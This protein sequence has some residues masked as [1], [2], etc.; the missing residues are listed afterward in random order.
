MDYNLFTKQMTGDWIAQSTNYYLTNHINQ[1]FYT[2]N[3]QIKWTDIKEKEV[4]LDLIRT[5][6]KKEDIVK[7]ISLYKI[8]SIDVNSLSNLSYILLSQKTSKQICLFKF[9]K[10]FH[11][12][13][14]FTLKDY[15]KNY[16]C[17]SSDIRNIRVIEKIYFLNNNVKIIKS[18]IK[19][20]NQC[21]GASFSS[22]IK[23][24]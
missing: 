20:N 3:N 5:I 1:N 2:L 4:Y 22:E 6:L 7:Y 17:L 12:M 24:S 23:I 16:L 8:E 14:Q 15:S 13:N 18:I 21:I 10:R 9:N 11:L 19:K